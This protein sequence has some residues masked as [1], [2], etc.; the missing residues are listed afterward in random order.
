[1]SE[2]SQSRFDKFNIQ[3]QIKGMG[4]CLSRRWR[5]RWFWKFQLCTFRNFLGNKLSSLSCSDATKLAPTHS[6]SGKCMEK[7]LKILTFFTW[8]CYSFGSRSVLKPL[9]WHSG[10]IGWV[11]QTLFGN[12]WDFEIFARFGGPEV[13]KMGI[14]WKKVNFFTF[15]VQKMGQKL[16]ISKN[17]K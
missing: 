16:K 15:S 14:F 1:M 12:F 17:P 10:F 11:I 8:K 4:G 13:E 2:R 3:K 9:F 7:S 6:F 5:F